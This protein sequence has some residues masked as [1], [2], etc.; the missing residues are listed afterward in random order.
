MRQ[1]SQH[2]GMER[3]VR[4]QVGTFDPQQIFD[5]A[6]DVMTL[7]HLRR[8]LQR[9]FEAFLSRFGVLSQTNAD[10]G[11]KPNTQC[12]RVQNRPVAGNDTSPLKLLHTAQ[13]GRWGQTDA[14]C[15]F[16]IADTPIQRKL[17]QYFLVYSIS[18][19]H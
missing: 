2:L 10:I 8:L 13:T 14:I 5:G 9:A 15:K 6:R 18:F 7:D 19:R 11:D 4:W 1:G 12:R 17:T 16:Q 3:F